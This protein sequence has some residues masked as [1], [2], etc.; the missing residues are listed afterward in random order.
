MPFRVL[1]VTGGRNFV[2]SRQDCQLLREL[3]SLYRVTHLINGACRGADKWST[4]LAEANGVQPVELPALWGFHS[5]G[6]AGPIRNSLMV[7]MGVRLASTPDDWIG[8]LQCPGGTGTADCTRKLEAN[9]VRVFELAE[10]RR[11]D[12]WKP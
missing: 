4:R 1:I 12:E 2:A 3:M 11:S 10:M 7:D 9:S 8:A 6:R 5:R